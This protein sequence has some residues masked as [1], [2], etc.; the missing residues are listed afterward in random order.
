MTTAIRRFLWIG[1]LGLLAVAPLWACDDGSFPTTT[2][3]SISSPAPANTPVNPPS[4]TL[5][6][7][8]TPA[9]TTVPATQPTSAPVV[10]ATPT[11]GPTVTPLVTETPTSEPVL[12]LSVTVAAVSSGLPQYD[13]NDW[14]HWTD[15]DG[16]CQDTR[17]EVLIVESLIPVTFRSDRECRV[18][19]GQ[20]FA[21]FTGT[22]V[23][24]A[25]RL[26]VDHLVPLANAHQ[27]GGWA[28][29]DEQKERYANSFDDPDHLIAVTASANRSKGAKAPDE[30][31]P[32]DHSYWCEYAIDWIRIKQTWELTVTPVEVEALQ[33]MLETCAT[34]HSLTVVQGEASSLPVSPTATP[35]LESSYASCDEAAEAG[36]QR[37]QGSSGAGR[38]FP[39]AVVPSAR[40]G[41]GDGVVCER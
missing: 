3:Q 31:R 41:D 9:P 26:D 21:A 17:H 30:W 7:T 14:N 24:E 40:D 22:T 33:E 28:W 19:T 2:E 5:E 36:E 39:Q 38:G 6:P 11:A 10:T 20:W 27:S 4:D 8:A 34:I 1:P 13:R 35:H 29:T 16:D 18:D 32:P 12:Q 37:V 25:S 15:E 23:T